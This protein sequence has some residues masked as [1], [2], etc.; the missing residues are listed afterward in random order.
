MFEKKFLT[1]NN[2]KFLEKKANFFKWMLKSFSI[3]I[4]KE[5]DIL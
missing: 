5:G 4:A 2:F 1:V 3:I